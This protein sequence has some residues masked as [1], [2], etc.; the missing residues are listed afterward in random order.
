MT[1][2]FANLMLAAVVALGPGK[3]KLWDFFYQWLYLWGG[4]H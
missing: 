2:K 1:G 3:D 4:K